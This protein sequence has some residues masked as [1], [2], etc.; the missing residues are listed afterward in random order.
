MPKRKRSSSSSQKNT[1]SLQS[2]RKALLI[3]NTYPDAKDTLLSPVNDINAMNDVLTSSCGFQSIS[4][5]SNL[6]HQQM[7]KAIS[8]FGESLNEGD[9]AVFYFSG[10][11][12]M[13]DGVLFLCPCNM[14][15][16]NKRSDI[17]NY[18][19]SFD[20]VI[21]SLIQGCGKG[22][23]IMIIDA[24]RDRRFESVRRTK[25]I[26]NGLPKSHTFAERMQ[27]P[28]SSN[29]YTMYASAESTDAFDG[30]TAQ[31][32][33]RFTR[34]LVDLLPTPGM[35]IYD[36]SMEVRRRSINSGA[37]SHDD[38]S[39]TKEFFFCNDIQKQKQL[40][41]EQE[42][43]QRRKKREELTY[44]KSQVDT[45]KEK[46]KRLE[47]QLKEARGTMEK[48]V[49]AMDTLFGKTQKL[50]EDLDTQ[51]IANDGVTK[52]LHR[53]ESELKKRD[54]EIANLINDNNGIKRR[55]DKEKKKTVLMQQRVADA[56]Q[57]RDMVVVELTQ[58][59]KD[60]EVARRR[61]D[62]L[63]KNIESLNGRL[64]GK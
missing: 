5:E 59:Q 50:A 1:T 62:A 6:N 8:K 32:L 21:E 55:V 31:D 39:M 4:S 49:A 25:S 9:V 46:N 33:S 18:C 42:R 23:K 58:T 28:Q 20:V 3:G 22:V 40:K 53:V 27:L 64:E 52:E 45:Q 61:E 15:Q 16:L 44:L 26:S 43:D 41:A 54:T 60:L 10:H 57:A 36:M 12:L 29:T 56:K 13:Y 7:H 24:C 37:I 11:G 34:V 35:R 17:K 47:I 30:E 38:I 19:I 14:P 48:Q 51:M 63:A 2:P